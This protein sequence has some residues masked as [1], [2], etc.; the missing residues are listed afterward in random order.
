MSLVFLQPVFFWL[1]P[2][3]AFFWFFPRS[4]KR[5]GWH[6]LLRTLV[7]LLLILGLARPALLKPRSG[8]SQV[9]IW[10]R[11]ESIPPA[12]GDEISERV[13][14]LVGKGPGDESWKVIVLNGDRTDDAEALEG[15]DLTPMKGSS[16]SAALEKAGRLIPDRARAAITLISDGKST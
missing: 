9:V 5:N 4:G 8:A 11:S 12:A 3:L 15:A 2:V 1:L 7:V 13:R 14:S 10:D 6:V 16:I